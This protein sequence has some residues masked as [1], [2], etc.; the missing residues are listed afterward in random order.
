MLFNRVKLKINLQHLK[1]NV[2]NIISV[3]GC[4]LIAM[5]KAN[6]Y[7]HGLIEV[8]NFLKNECQVNDFGL[9]SIEEAVYLRKVTNDYRTRLIIFSDIG[10]FDEEALLMCKNEKI[11]PVISSYEDLDKWCL[12]KKNHSIPLYLKLNTGMNRLGIPFDDSSQLAHE[13]IKRGITKVDHLMT[14]FSSSELKLCEQSKSFHQYE[15]FK[16]AKNELVK[17]NITIKESSVANSG[18]IE[19]GLGFDET[20]VR[21]GIILYGASVL[22]DEIKSKI[23]TNLVSS[24]EAS[25]ISSFSVQKGSEIGYG[26]VVIDRSGELVLVSV[27]YG[28]GIPTRMSGV[29]LKT[30]KGEGVVVGRINMD[31]TSILFPNGKK[32]K[33]GETIKIWGSDASD[34]NR[35]SKEAK[36]IPYEILCNVGQRV[37][38]EYFLN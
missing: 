22:A 13:L 6:A 26:D 23:Q 7:G 3:S 18:A 34:L 38:K 28:D 33:K 24:M 4:Q 37:K 9:A 16:S 15:K 19:Q 20:H 21:P 8:Y 32:I 11:I 5:I 1:Q 31:M 27:G 29:T 25:V 30:N 17:N 10:S 14:H 12:F 2:E 36:I 35:I